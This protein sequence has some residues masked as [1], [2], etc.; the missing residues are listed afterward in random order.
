MVR[1]TD[2]P[3]MIIVAYSGCKAIHC[4]DMTIAVYSGRKATHIHARTHARAYWFVTYYQVTL[5]VL[6]R[7]VYSDLSTGSGVLFVIY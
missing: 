2:Y 4:P 6:L 1:L 3:D 7:K 5:R